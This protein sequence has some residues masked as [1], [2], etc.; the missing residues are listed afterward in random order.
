[1]SQLE[2]TNY[3]EEMGRE[4]LENKVKSLM[5]CLFFITT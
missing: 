1:M 4:M 5:E 2:V 3:N